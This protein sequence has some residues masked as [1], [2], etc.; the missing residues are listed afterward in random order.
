MALTDTTIRQAKARDNDWK[1]ADGKGLYLLV[2]KT[3]SKLWRLKFRV[4]GKEKK[5][6]LGSYP[7][8]GLKEARAKRDEARRL[9]QSGS[10][11]SSVKRERRI[12]KK[13]ATANTFDAIA[14]EY[15]AK[16]EA[17]GRAGATIGKTRW[18]L[19]K[20]SPALG[21]RPIGE[22]TPHEL[23]AVLK[24]SER[25]GHR[26][27]ARRLRSFA[28][29][30]FRYA[31]ATVRAKSDPAQ[32][33][34]GALVSPVAKHHAAIT[35]PVAFGGLLRA[36]EEYS[37][38]PVTCLA[39]RFT[40]HV[41]QRPG[42][43]RQAEWTEI[44]FEN[45]VWTIPAERMKQRHAHRVPLSRQALAILSEA[46]ELTGGGRYV[47]PK[48][49]SSL[50]PMS[51]N[52]INGALR[53]L[54]YGSDRMTAHGFRSTASSLLNESGKWSYD[55]I[56]RAL[57]HADRNQVRAAYH[58]GTHWLERVEMAQWWSDYLDQLRNGAD[59][60]LFTDRN[61]G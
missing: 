6:A 35:D 20:L 21:S 59:I 41:F 14:E 37:G 53:R 1:L 55:A 42:E 7:E 44:D 54:G 23:L 31:V 46:H 17:E 2:T 61:A 60:V 38:Q 22:I 58:R 10:D 25:A 56:E 26:E 39:L 28:S 24:A 12:A 32:P 15:I 16:I 50:K 11:P 52:A 47:F 8:I 51:E 43:I 18:L 29:R 49:G 3:G 40:P 9:V 33:L 48:L 57:S 30:V 36:I 45:A 13:L 4:G 34:R 19:S 5:L 27:T